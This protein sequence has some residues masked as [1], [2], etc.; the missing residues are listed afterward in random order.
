MDGI[1]VGITIVLSIVQFF[2][3]IFVEPK[4]PIKLKETDTLQRIRK[5]KNDYLISILVIGIFTM[6]LAYYGVKNQIPIL[7]MI[8]GIFL[9]FLLTGARTIFDRLEKKEKLL[10]ADNTIPTIR[11]ASVKNIILKDE[12]IRKSII[13]DSIEKINLTIYFKTG[14]EYLAKIRE[15]RLMPFIGNTFQ[16]EILQKNIESIEVEET[17][18][19]KVKLKVKTK[20]GNTF[21]KDIEKWELPQHIEIE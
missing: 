6:F 13:I 9:I 12:Q 17:E 11:D 2:V 4:I 21:Q 1:I 15:E 5:R 3:C 20:T 19:D 8:F 18:K 7:G 10:L 16:K 14:E